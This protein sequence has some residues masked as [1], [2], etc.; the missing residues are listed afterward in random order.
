MVVSKWEWVDL[1]PC[2]PWGFVMQML[3]KKSIFFLFMIVSL[4]PLL[5]FECSCY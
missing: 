4:L 2:A 3:K 5:A 1:L